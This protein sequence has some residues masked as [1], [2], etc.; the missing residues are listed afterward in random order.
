[1][2]IPG[3]F[4]VAGLWMALIASLIL[5]LLN[6]IVK[7]IL[8]LLSLPLTLLTFGLFSFVINAAMLTLTSSL[9]GDTYFGFSSFG[10]ALIV[11]VC[12][13]IINA[14]VSDYNVK[15]YNP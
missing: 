10:S 11:A 1:M 9:I 8:S 5:S 6:M 14:L 4:H 15:K 2:I 7:P 12:L 3:R 13:S